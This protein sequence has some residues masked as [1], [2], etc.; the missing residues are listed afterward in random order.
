MY[1]K[2]E[3]D[4]DVNHRRSSGPLRDPVG[5]RSEKGKVR[6]LCCTDVQ[7]YSS[8]RSDLA[9]MYSTSE[10]HLVWSVQAAAAISENVS[11][12]Q[13]ETNEGT[14]TCENV[15]II[16]I[17]PSRQRR[18]PYHSAVTSSETDT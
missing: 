18:T 2:E 7:R 14:F 1:D 16:N 12:S 13:H 11:E 10:E 15:A 9:P 17:L 8:D 5:V 6:T 4:R 3:I